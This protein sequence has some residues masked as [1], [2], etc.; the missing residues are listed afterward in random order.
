MLRLVA[1]PNGKNLNCC[2][3]DAPLRLSPD[4]RSA[5]SPIGVHHIPLAVS[6]REHGWHRPKGSY[7]RH[8]NDPP[9]RRM[10]DFGNM[11][12]LETSVVIRTDRKLRNIR[13]Y[14]V[15]RGVDPFAAKPR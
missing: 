1:A 11:R 15:R 3:D 2:L 12:L 6:A 4:A 8:Q 14:D 7:I 5:I 9:F 10:G 13:S